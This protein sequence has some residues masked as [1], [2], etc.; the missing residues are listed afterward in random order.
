MHVLNVVS[1]PFVVGPFEQSTPEDVIEPIAQM[2]EIARTVGKEQIDRPLVSM[3]LMDG[4]AS[5]ME[6]FM[7][8]SAIGTTHPETGAKMWTGDRI[9]LAI[10]PDRESLRSSPS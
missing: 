4:G 8:L 2:R 6:A 1:W 9:P 10:I 5:Q 7:I 3:A